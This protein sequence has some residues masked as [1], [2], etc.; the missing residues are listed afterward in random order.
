M[1][2]SGK[3]RVN[4]RL[5]EARI[6]RRWS[7]QELAERVGTTFNNVSR[8]ERG[9]TTPG[10]Y[11]RTRL[12]DLFD[13]SAEALGL[14]PAA[15]DRINSETQ[16]YDPAIPPPRRLIGRTVL[17]RQ[18]RQQLCTAAP[19]ER[20]ALHGLPGVG[21]TALAIALVHDR[22]L[23][24]QFRDGI[25]WVGLGPQPNIPALLGRWG[26]LLGIAVAE[27]VQTGG[28]DAW[29]LALRMAIGK[30]HMLL[31]LDDVWRLE[32]AL[33]LQVAGPHCSYLLTTRFPDLA[34]QYADEQAFRVC[35]LSE[36]DGI[37][38]MSHLAPRATEN[39]T[40]RVRAL[41]QAV[42][43]LPLALTLIGR[44]LHL[45][46]RMQ[47]PRRL[48]TTLESL[49]D[50][51]QR[52]LLALPQA[53]LERSPGLPAHM[54]I[55]L[56]AA[57][58][59]SDHFLDDEGRIAL[60]ALAAFP[61]KPDTFSEEAAL[62]V[63]GLPAAV[64]DRLSDAGLLENGGP[65]RYSLHQTI[66]DY[67]R[68]S[69]PAASS[70]E[71]LVEYIARYVEEHASDSA[72]LEQESATIRAALEIAFEQNMLAPLVRIINAFAPFLEAHGLY[73]QAVL[74]LRRAEPAARSLAD[75]SALLTILLHLGRAGAQLGAY[76]QAEHCLHEGLH[77]AAE[78]NDDEQ[79][80]NIRIELGKALI[81]RERY[82]QAER[83]LLE[84]LPADRSTQRDA[85]RCRLLVPL[86]MATMAR[87]NFVQAESYLQEG[88]ALARRCQDDEQICH[89]LA[90]LGLV[91]WN[92]GAIES[93]EAYCR[94][95]LEL[96]HSLHN[97]ER[98]CSLLALMG[99]VAQARGE[100]GQS[101]AHSREGLPLAR[102][103]G[104]PELSAALL[105]NL[106]GA[107]VALHEYEE[108]ERHLLGALSIT[109]QLGKLED[110]CYA[111]FELGELYLQQSRITEAASV[112]ERG[113]TI[114][115]G[116]RH[117]TMRARFGLAR[118]LA[119]R[120]DVSEARQQA[121][122]LLAACDVEDRHFS[123][124]VRRW[125]RTPV[126]G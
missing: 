39:E 26:A 16:L 85:Q 29:A 15:S 19:V 20:L 13:Q 36:Q 42:G 91:H 89:L 68:L 61:S 50:A 44:H 25:L 11:F 1:P 115:E 7:Q 96:A 98:I 62:A 113:L 92:R 69:G 56:Q 102:R 40:E 9:I 53:P 125:L 122:E 97:S 41:V 27:S 104:N 37:H 31:V 121:E 10:A 30:R 28:P 81:K 64:L 65:G 43:A 124:K 57:I 46:E 107:E 73:E 21:K 93:A 66:A 45:Q 75:R 22:E 118:V 95:A 59:L 80:L 112:F 23:Q 2:G 87:G 88:L 32:D 12:C 108:A 76:E 24:E 3:T 84:G 126:Q 71:R 116:E 8:W 86:G 120:G 58:A 35:E 77:L 90:A 83:L 114:A 17:M 51:Q 123:R 111:L 117:L 33:A 4:Q 47:Q 52:F 109:Q 5:R 54:P 6:R 70:Q 78:L 34:F 101:K 72:A 94:K 82:E 48:H 18:I 63:T 103:S 38:L 119:A 110:T 67:A 14:L 74:H 105:L 55:S 106:G 60:R 100:Y 79:T 99:L 49:H